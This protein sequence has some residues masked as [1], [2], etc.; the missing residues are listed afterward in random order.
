MTDTF[1][2]PFAVWCGVLA[3]VAVGGLAVFARGRRNALRARPVPGKVLRVAHRS[4]TSG[5][6]QSV[7]AEV[8]VTD[9]LGKQA[10]ILTFPDGDTGGV[11]AGRELTMW[12]RPDGRTPPRLQRPG[13][14][15]RSLPAAGAALAALAFIV[16][17]HV[18]HIDQ[19]SKA[20]LKPFGIV[21]AASC[22]VVAA[23]NVARLFKTRR[24][25]RGTPVAGQVIG[26]VRHVTTNQDNTTSTTY[27]PIVSFTAADGRQVYGLTTTATSTRKKWTGRTV[28]IRHEPGR[29]ENFRLAKPSESWAPTLNILFCAVLI[30]GGVVATIYGL[31]K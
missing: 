1:G 26:L 23:V 19:N 9:P 5:K 17:I 30:A 20:A 12:Q 8:A 10:V 2:L 25:L 3:L 18:A 14:S 6:V 28:Q 31:R 29:P 16:D 27:R 7:M 4:N 22:A 15:T 24:I 21:F 13:R 11:W